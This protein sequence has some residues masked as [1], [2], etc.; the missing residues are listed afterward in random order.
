MSIFF[1]VIVLWL[2]YVKSFMGLI[3]SPLLILI[4]L[5]FTFNNKDDTQWLNQKFETSGSYSYCLF[6][7]ILYLDASL[8]FIDVYFFSP[9]QDI[10][11]VSVRFLQIPT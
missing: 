2:G 6:S 3:N 7:L 11:D 4:K 8:L 1:T 5:V 9:C 10:A